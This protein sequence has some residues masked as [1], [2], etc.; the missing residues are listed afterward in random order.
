VHIYDIEKENGL[1]DYLC[2][3]QGLGVSS[4]I[5][6]ASI[7]SSISDFDSIISHL[8]SLSEFKNIEDLIGNDQPDLALIVSILASVGWNLNDDI[9]TPSELWKAR[10][11]AIHKPMNHM[12]NGSVILGHII[13]SFAVDKSGNEIST[14][15]V[16][17]EFDVQ[18]AG[19]LYKFIPERKELIE[20]ILSKANED[21]MFVSMECWFNDFSYGF[22]DK[23][24]GKTK[25]VERNESTAFLTK[26]LKIFHGTGE[27]EGHRVG[28]VLKDFIF[29]GQGFVEEPANPESVIKVAAQRGFEFSNLDNISRGGADRMDQKEIDGMQKELEEVKAELQKLKSENDELTK[30]LEIVKAEDFETKIDALKAKN[31]ELNTGVTEANEKIEAIQ[32]EKVELQKKLDEAVG[33]VEKAKSELDKLNKSV[34]AKERF[35]KLSKIQEIEDK[36]KTLAELTEMTDETFALVLK[37]AKKDD[38]DNSENNDSGDDDNSAQAVLDGAKSN[39]DADLQPGNDDSNEK[40]SKEFVALAHTLTGN[41]HVEEDGGG[42]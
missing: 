14:E 39:E 3:D 25:I 34:I 40:E 31:S 42:E 35:E 18:V 27:F 8:R 7:T 22:L 16:P 1:A 38:G 26:H 23:E 30:S 13:K 36:D 11:T 6:K 24:T 32:K 29:G 37:Y 12:H 10:E 17:D 2:N 28:R 5:T 19:V 15:I 41:R 21:Q 4:T 20:N 9:F 33:N